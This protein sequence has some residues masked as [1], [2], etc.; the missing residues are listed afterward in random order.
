MSIKSY[1][2]FSSSQ[3][4]LS[5]FDLALCLPKKILFFKHEYSETQLFKGIHCCIIFW[6]A[7]L[8]YCMNGRKT[9]MHTRLDLSSKGKLLQLIKFCSRCIAN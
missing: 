8:Q 7:K 5:S 6:Y 3:N 1:Y 9:S 4:S 2:E